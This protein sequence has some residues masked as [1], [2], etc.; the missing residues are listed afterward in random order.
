MKNQLM[1]MNWQSNNSKTGNSSNAR[2]ALLSELGALGVNTDAISY[3]TTSQ[4]S[5]LCQGLNKIIKENY[6]PKSGLRRKA[7]ATFLSTITLMATIISI[8][9]T[10][11]LTTP[12]SAYG[13]TGQRDRLVIFLGY[14]D[15]EVAKW[16]RLY[17]RSFT[18]L[19]TEF[20]PLIKNQNVKLV[21]APHTKDLL[22]AYTSLLP[23]LRK[24]NPTGVF[25]FV[26]KP[27]QVRDF[28]MVASMMYGGSSDVWKAQ[29]AAAIDKGFAIVL[30][31]EGLIS[32]VQ[33][34]MMHLIDCGTWHNDDFGGP[35]PNGEIRKY[36]GA[37]SL[38]WCNVS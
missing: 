27:T 37:A 32:T 3:A 16:Q 33:H 35:L 15:K 9:L 21:A 25:V 26:V 30:E 13:A 34:E 2:E 20:A 1:A 24:D 36:P 18:D 7:E 14:S 5:G 38:T 6:V 22:G 4:L 12:V 8:T 17:D 28:R 19:P 23:Q 11:N 29:G 10:A 31:N